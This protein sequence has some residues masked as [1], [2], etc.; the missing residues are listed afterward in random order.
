MSRGPY[1]VRQADG[2]YQAL[3]QRG[4]HVLR[5]GLGRDAPGGL[6]RLLASLRRLRG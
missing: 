6:A 3:A 1:E 4:R 5:A 2:D